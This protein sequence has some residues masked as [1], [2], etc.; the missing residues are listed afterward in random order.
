MA[1]TN[2]AIAAAVADSVTLCLFDEAGA[3]TQIPLADNDA[4]VWHAFAPGIGPGQAYGFTLRGSRARE[5]LARPTGSRCGTAWHPASAACTCARPHAPR[6]K[7]PGG[8][9]ACGRLVGGGGDACRLGHLSIV[10]GRTEV[11]ITARRRTALVA[12]PG[13]LRPLPQSPASLILPGPPAPLMI[14]GMWLGMCCVLTGWA[15]G[16]APAVAPAITRLPRF[17]PER[18]DDS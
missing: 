11:V 7:S 14:M 6:C 12:S 1:G 3:E 8:E 10:S 2:F 4:D 17:P 15:A 9:I 5:R 16:D 18:G 13:W